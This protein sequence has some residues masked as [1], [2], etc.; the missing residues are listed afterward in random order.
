MLKK[1]T[2]V[3]STTKRMTVVNYCKTADARF[4]ITQCRLLLALRRNGGPCKH[5]SMAWK[6]LFSCKTKDR[7]INGKGLVL[8]L[9]GCP[10]NL[11]I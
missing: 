10:A 9:L 1:K 6:R 8:V 5:I 11:I 3:F 4:L 7:E 2:K